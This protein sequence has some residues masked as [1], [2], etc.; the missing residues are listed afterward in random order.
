[1]CR[2]MQNCM[3]RDGMYPRMLLITNCKQRHRSQPPPLSPQRSAATAA[4]EQ[5]DRLAVGSFSFDACGH[6]AACCVL[7]M[8]LFAVDHF[9]PRQFGLIPMVLHRLVH[10]L[11]H[12]DPLPACIARAPT[13]A[14]CHATCGA[15]PSHSNALSFLSFRAPLWPSRPRCR[16]D[17]RCHSAVECSPKAP[18]RAVPCYPQCH[19]L[20]GHGPVR[21]LLT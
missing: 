21:P 8:H 17:A 1:M 7:H 4:D 2:F 12:L 5:G 10:L 6:V 11:V 13:V 18:C 9:D 19:F 3:M 15:H 16:I 20:R 14:T